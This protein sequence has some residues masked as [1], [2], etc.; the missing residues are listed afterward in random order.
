MS[1]CWRYCTLVLMMILTTGCNDGY[2]QSNSFWGAVAGAGV[3]AGLGYAACKD[4]KSS[5]RNACMIGGGIIGGIIGGYIGSYMDS[6]DQDRAVKG[7]R[8]TPNKKNYNWTNSRTGN[9]FTIKPLNKSKQGNQVCRDYIIYGRK[10]GS[11][12]LNK[13]RG[14][15]C[16]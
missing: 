9:R 15:T 1:T 10:K 16:V 13:Q 11:S 8:S 3:G 6:S 5:K 2:Y 14:H 7:L 4:K 12:K